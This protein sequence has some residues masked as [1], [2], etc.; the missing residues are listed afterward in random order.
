MP[1]NQSVSLDPHSVPSTVKW[2]MWSCQLFTT[3]QHVWLGMT[4][5]RLRCRNQ[6]SWLSH[7]STYTIVVSV[8]LFIELPKS[9]QVCESL[10][11]SCH[12]EQH[13]IH[14]GKCHGVSWESQNHV[15]PVSEYPWGIGQPKRHSYKFVVP[16]RGDACCLVFQLLFHAQSRCT[17]FH[18]DQK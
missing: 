12:L 15:D 2:P 14:L 18:R 13:V 1:E 10:V 7:R 8:P 11:Y 3:L 4:R 9:S 6:G 17:V 16:V 5:R